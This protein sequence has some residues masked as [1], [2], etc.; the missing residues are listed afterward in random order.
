MERRQDVAIRYIEVFLYQIFQLSRVILKLCPLIL[1]LYSPLEVSNTDEVRR[2]KLLARPLIM[3]V[4]NSNDTAV[5]LNIRRK[6]SES[7][8]AK[9][10]INLLER[11]PLRF[12]K[13]KDK[14]GQCDDKIESCWCKSIDQRK[15]PRSLLTN[16]EEIEL[17]T[18]LL[19]GKGTDLVPESAH[20]P[21]TDTCGECATLSSDLIWHYLGHVRPGYRTKRQREDDCDTE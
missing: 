10:E 4:G 14:G 1:L 18:K 5:L 7:S 15:A 8:I 19:E 13:S 17:P 12:S 16:E 20:K 9:H 21:V 6:V 2:S 11:Q 3:G